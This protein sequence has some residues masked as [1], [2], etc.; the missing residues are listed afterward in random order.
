ML[1]N[2]HLNLVLLY[3]LKGFGQANEHTAYITVQPLML[4]KNCQHTQYPIV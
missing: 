2:F 1:G 3:T 4:N